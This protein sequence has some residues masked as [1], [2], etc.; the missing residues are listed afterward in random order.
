MVGA[1]GID[2]PRDLLV[3]GERVG[4]RAGVSVCRATRTGKVSRP[5]SSTQALNGDSDGP[6]CRRI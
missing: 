2:Q 6:V 4:D 1:A 3:A 5:L